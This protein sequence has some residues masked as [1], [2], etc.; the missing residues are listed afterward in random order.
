M[1]QSS[2]LRDEKTGRS[3]KI[4]NILESRSGENILRPVPGKTAIIHGNWRGAVIVNVDRE[5]VVEEWDAPDLMVSS[6]H[7]LWE[8][9]TEGIDGPWRVLYATVV[10]Y[11]D[12]ITM[13]SKL[14]PLPSDILVTELSN[15]QRWV[16][17]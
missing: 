1:T 7:S 4:F 6:T 14:N 16:V 12:V 11:T 10:G 17:T 9:E 13:V 2:V 5:D 8:T 15:W 3:H